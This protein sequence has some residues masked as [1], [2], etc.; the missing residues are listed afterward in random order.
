MADRI[1]SAFRGP[2]RGDEPLAK[3]VLKEG[4]ERSLLRRHPWVFSGA[5]DRVEG[6]PGPGETVNVLAAD[7]RFLGRGA[8]SPAS[9]IRVRIWTFHETEEID[10]AFFAGRIRA[11]VALREGLRVPAETNAYRLVYSES[12]GLPGLIV[13]RY[14]DFVVCQFLGAGVEYFKNTF[15]ESLRALIGVR[16][17]YERSDADV[18]SK[19]GLKP[20]SGLLWG[21]EPPSLVEI[22][23]DRIRFLVDIMHGHKTG[24]YLDQRPNRRLVGM[25]SDGAEVLNCFS[26]T[27]GFGL[28]ALK[29]GARHVTNVE[30][31]AGLI[32]LTGRNM[33]LNGFDRSHC[34]NVQGDVFR[35]LRQYREEGRSYDMI[36]LDPPK[37]AD[38]QSHLP[39]ASRGYKDINRLAFMLL[40]PGGLLFTFSCSG[41]MK[42]DLFQKIVADAALDAGRDAQILA[43]LGQAPDH[44]VSLHIPEIRYLK[45]LL[46]RVKD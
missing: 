15:V 12:D 24:F 3:I 4:R 18:R 45:G 5:V 36:V 44:P 40:R 34:E 28:A 2:P 19:E 37:F 16:G 42:M 46:L 14:A 35:V 41:V 10:T 38:A 29:G 13:D 30:D 21:E 8:Y 31:V 17:I 11:A 23:E 43:W 33:D 22:T 25:H 7:G 1:H 9:Q 20:C 32:E 6:S 26:Y 39:R 27:G